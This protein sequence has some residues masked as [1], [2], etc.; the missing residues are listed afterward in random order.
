MKLIPLTFIPLTL[1]LVGCS[2]RPN[3]FFWGGP[4]TSPSATTSPRAGVP[5]L[6]TTAHTNITLSWSHPATNAEFNVYSAPVPHLAAMTLK[7]RTPAQQIT[8]PAHR[9]AEFFGVRAVRGTNESPWA[10]Q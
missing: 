8:F 6:P 3:P 5:E 10:T 2:G 9:S 7:A 4:R 1:L